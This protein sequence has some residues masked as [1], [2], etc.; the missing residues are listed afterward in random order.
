M[1][2][3]ILQSKSLMSPFKSLKTKLDPEILNKYELNMDDIK[4]LA[5]K[6]LKEANTSLVQDN[7]STLTNINSQIFQDMNNNN[8]VNWAILETVRSFYYLLFE[9]PEWKVKDYGTFLAIT[10]KLAKY[11]D[12]HEL[13]PETRVNQ[14][15]K[16]AKYN[17][18]LP[19]ISFLYNTMNDDI[20]SQMIKKESKD[21]NEI[22]GSRWSPSEFLNIPDAFKAC[23]KSQNEAGSVKGSGNSIAGDFISKGNGIKP[24][25]C[26]NSTIPSQ[27]SA[28]CEWHSEVIQNQ[29]KKTFVS[30]MG[31]SLPPR[32]SVLEPLTSL[33]NDLGIELFDDAKPTVFPTV[34]I[35]G[36]CGHISDCL[37]HEIF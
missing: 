27:C 29:S 22:V 6:F 37:G 12:C 34:A 4:D 2:K 1:G 7:F 9:S 18:S 8:Y 33:Q 3:N 16:M 24:S 31:L 21:P 28:Y 26:A 36:Q 13:H 23:F 25:I 32:K 5:L 10:L 14:V 17:I 30:L 35:N 11:H 15:F 19:E 20:L